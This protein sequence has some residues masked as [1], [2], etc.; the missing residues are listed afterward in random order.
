MKFLLL[1]NSKKKQNKNKNKKKINRV[2]DVNRRRGQHMTSM[3]FHVKKFK[4]K[5]NTCFYVI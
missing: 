4:R 5:K 1:I 3:K 2:I